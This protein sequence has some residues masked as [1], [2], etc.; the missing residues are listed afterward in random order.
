MRKVCWFFL[1]DWCYQNDRTPS[2]WALL[3]MG[4]SQ[5]SIRPDQDMHK[6]WLGCLVKGLVDGLFYHAAIQQHLP[7]GRHHPCLLQAAE[8][9]QIKFK[10]W[11]TYYVRRW[12]WQDEISMYVK[13][14][15]L[16]CWI[17]LEAT[18]YVNT[19]LGK[20]KTGQI[21]Y[22]LVPVHNHFHGCT[23]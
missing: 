21:M 10:Y 22:L 2:R 11:T 1:G 19:R 14:F 18:Q 17:Y 4:Y 16:L 3:V 6:S 5:L 9:K 13:V 23:Q 20:V 7:S 15:A 8:P 12:K